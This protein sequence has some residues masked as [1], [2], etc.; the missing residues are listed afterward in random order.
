M[1][2]KLKAI[3]SKLRALDR[4]KVET[5]EKVDLLNEIAELLLTGEDLDRLSEVAALSSSLARKLHYKRGEA[6]GLT[7]MGAAQWFL[8][9]NRDAEQNLLRG[10][11][12]FEKLGDQ[13]GIAKST[14]HLAGVYRSLGDYGQ[15]I[16]Y[17]LSPLE[18]FRKNP[19]PFWQGIA[20]VSLGGTYHLIGDFERSLQQHQECAKQTYDHGEKWIAGRALDGIGMTYQSMG[21]PKKALLYFKKS[22][23]VFEDL[24]YRMGKAKALNSLG[25]VYQ[26]LGD[27][28]QALEFYLKSLKIREEIQ[29][30]G[31]QCTTLINLGR[32]FI[33]QGNRI[34]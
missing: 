6:Y 29:Q 24:G 34:C 3:E 23:Q 20:L 4:R 27:N 8:G 21:K 28:A 15:S 9:N 32:L 30:K 12:L 14:V 19:N 13:E 2:E 10:K 25:S 31:A 18:Y 17:S 1:K 26:L 22:L 11:S 5:I 16:S 33:H 7:Y